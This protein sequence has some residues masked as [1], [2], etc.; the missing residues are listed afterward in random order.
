MLKTRLIITDLFWGGSGSNTEKA[1][2]LHSSTL[3]WKIPW[4]EKPGRLQSMGSHRVGHDWSDLAAG[5][6]RAWLAS[7]NDPIFF[8]FSSFPHYG[9][10]WWLSGKE[11]T[12]TMQETQV[13]SP[14]WEDLT[15]CGATKPGNCNHWSSRVLEPVLR[16]KRSTCNKKPAHCTREQPLLPTTREK[17]EHHWRQ[18]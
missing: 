12:C 3:A 4:I 14:F 13:W 11:S 1:M 6:N 18:L 5:S 10:P 15:C 7:V 8:F 2:A 17:F 9:L 16:N